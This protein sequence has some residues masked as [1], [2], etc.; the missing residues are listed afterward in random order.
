M[1][2]K[3]RQE[4]ILELLNQK[5]FVT[6][7][8]ISETLFISPSSVRRDLSELERKHILKRS[9]GGAR[10]ITAKSN[11]VAFG[12]RSYDYVEAKQAI[13]AKAARLV[14]E[15][16]VVFLDQSSTC[17]FLAMELARFQNLTVVTNNL[18]ILSLLSRTE[19]TVIA[20]GGIVSRENNNCLLGG[21]AQRGFSEINADLMFFSAN[22]I[23]NAGV[24]T[25]CTQE[26]IFLRHAM[27]DHA[28]RKVFLCDSSKLGK[29]APYVQCDLTRIDTL[30]SET[31]AFRPLAQKFPNLIII[32][33]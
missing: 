27:L 32:D 8:E 16:N 17:Y 14:K 2:K 24:I 9:Y 12:A 26:E 15:G 30:I 22:A 21:G 4:R 19:L 6:V 13:A 29:Q 31:D 1:I 18:E 3:E 7:A 10:L 20:T 28:A 5:E 33:N 25:D 23:T 11:V